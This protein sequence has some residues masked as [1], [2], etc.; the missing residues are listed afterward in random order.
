[1]A[2]CCCTEI[3]LYPCASVCCQLVC[4]KTGDKSKL[5]HTEYISNHYYGY[6]QLLHQQNSKYL[7]VQTQ[8]VK[9]SKA[10]WSLYVPPGLTFTNCTFCPHSLFMRF[11]WIS[12]QTAVI[13]LYSIN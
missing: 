3:T 11:V 6:T 4:T 1:M 12:E 13:S 10:Q 2:L 7:T 5:L 8:A 9:S